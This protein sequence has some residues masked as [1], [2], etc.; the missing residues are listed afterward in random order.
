[1]RI[2]IKDIA[3]KAGVSKTTVSFALNKPGR[4]SAETRD[5]ILTIVKEMGYV[6]DPVART[7]TTKRLGAL[8]LLLPQPISEALRNPYLCEII[9]GIGSA[10]EARE[11]S[12]TMLP[13]VR[14]KII[15]AA[16][17][18]FVDGILTIGVGADHEVVE[19][20]HRRHVPFVTIDG[21]PSDMTINVGIDDEDAAYRLMKYLIGLGHRKIAIFA[22]KPDI[23]G[24][25]G[26]HFSLVSKER[27]DG[28]CR[29]LMEAG[30]AVEGD[31]SG[32]CRS[33]TGIRPPVEEFTDGRLRCDA[34]WRVTSSQVECSR[35]GGE[36]AARELLTG[37]PA[38]ARPTAIVA[39][40][41][42]VA[43]GVMD[44]CYRLG[45]GIPGEI[46]LV[47]FDDIP[48]AALANPPLTTLRQPGTEKGRVAAEMVLDILD[49]GEVSH[50]RLEA[51][52]VVRASTAIPC[53]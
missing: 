18:S 6:P 5:R 7:L 27:M 19:L 52:L 36:S 15:E 2:T 22:L 46:S 11:L 4:I 13:P 39:M 47:G 21:S 28:F 41:D 9:R 3:E 14:G 23:F 49:G 24:M 20:L 38:S 40:A 42:V 25:A 50:R 34:L 17:R 1:M 48:E 53:L 43:L 8:G 30:C 31:S 45:I 35:S 10:C 51:D 26:D 44:T 33:G 32:R 37:V 12:L 29:A 16:R